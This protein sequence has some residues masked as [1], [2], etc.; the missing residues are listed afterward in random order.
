MT[1]ESPPSNDAKGVEPDAPAVAESEPSEP[2]PTVRLRDR[3]AAMSDDEKRSFVAGS[4]GFKSVTDGM[5]GFKSVTDGM[6]GF[7][8]VGGG[9]TGLSDSITKSLGVTKMMEEATRPVSL[10]GRMVKGLDFGLGKA[11]LP[12]VKVPDPKDYFTPDIADQTRRMTEQSRRMAEMVRDIDPSTFPASRSATAAEQTATYTA[13]LLEAMR[14]SIVLAEKTRQDNAKAA[15]FTRIVGWFSILG[16]A[17]AVASF[18]VAVV[19]LTK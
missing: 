12:A 16:I 15:T 13:D 9:V 8:M 7:K 5:T 3:V 2:A 11:V 4:G 6:P 1:D 18:V 14:E 10:I 19:A 17:L